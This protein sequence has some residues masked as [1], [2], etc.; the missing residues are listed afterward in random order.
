MN[1]SKQLIWM[2]GLGFLSFTLVGVGTAS[3]PRDARAAAEA[4]PIC[5]PVAAPAYQ[6]A[7]ALA[8]MAPQGVGTGGTA[9]SGPP[10]DRETGTRALAIAVASPN[11]PTSTSL[12]FLPLWSRQ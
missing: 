12:I 7:Q 11:V 5:R 4:T 3:S 2:F 8:E 1:I 10:L 9:G 6:P